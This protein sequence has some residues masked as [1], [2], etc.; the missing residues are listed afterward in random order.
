MAEAYELT[1]SSG[2]HTAHQAFI[3]VA[4]AW[5][6]VIALF[7]QVGVTGE[8]KYVMQ[9]SGKLKELAAQEKQ[10]MLLLAEV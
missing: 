2:I 5:S 1:G 9:A 7:E 3:G 8:R 4:E 10:A 6:K